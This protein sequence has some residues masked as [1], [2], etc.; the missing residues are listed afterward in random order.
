MTRD[1]RVDAYIAR[2][3]EFEQGMSGMGFGKARAKKATQT[4][5]LRT[6]KGA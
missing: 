3:Q 6:R 1:S 2:Q 5:A 4:R